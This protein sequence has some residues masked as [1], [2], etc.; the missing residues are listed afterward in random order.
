M[1]HSNYTQL[2]ELPWSWPHIF[3]EI[4]WLELLEEKED[5]AMVPCSFS[6]EWREVVANFLTRFDVVAWDVGPIKR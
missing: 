1:F 6:R 2:E 4:N 3:S 5:V